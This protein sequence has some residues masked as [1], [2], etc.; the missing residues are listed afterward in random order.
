MNRKG[1]I[2]NNSTNNNNLLYVLGILAYIV[3]FSLPH[4]ALH[5]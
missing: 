3:F 5:F 1:S 2:I 4:V